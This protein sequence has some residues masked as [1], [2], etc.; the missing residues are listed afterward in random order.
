M[1]DDPTPHH[2]A[3]ADQL[4][5][6]IRDATRAGRLPQDVIDLMDDLGATAD[7]VRG[8]SDDALEALLLFVRL[9]RSVWLGRLSAMI[10]SADDAPPLPPE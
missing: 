1:S 3:A 2:T 9:G 10:L 5:A 4:V 7:E 6:A 8:M